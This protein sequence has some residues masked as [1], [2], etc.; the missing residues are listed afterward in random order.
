MLESSKRWAAVERGLAEGTIR[1]YE[2]ELHSLA[3]HPWAPNNCAAGHTPTVVL[4][5]P[6]GAEWPL[7]VPTTGGFAA[8]AA[9]PMTRLWTLI[10]PRPGL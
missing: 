1:A 6:S 9:A 8:A 4:L 5:A 3:D 7:F 10:G 2:R